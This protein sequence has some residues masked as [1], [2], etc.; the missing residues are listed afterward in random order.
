MKE[1]IAKVVATDDIVKVRPITVNNMLVFEDVDMRLYDAYELE[2][3]KNP[4][5]D[6]D[7]EQRKFEL[8]KSALQGMSNL[9]NWKND[10]NELAECAIRI[11][12]A[13]IKKLREK[14]YDIERTKDRS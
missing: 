3:D 1:F 9:R 14:E 2:F 8:V 7:W 5:Y 6:I 13:I 4:F 12:D 10:E 11:S